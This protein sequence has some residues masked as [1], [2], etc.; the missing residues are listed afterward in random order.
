MWKKTNQP[1]THATVVVDFSCR[2]YFESLFSSSFQEA[3][4]ILIKLG[5]CFC[6]FPEGCR[7]IEGKEDCDLVNCQ[8]KWK[9]KPTCNQ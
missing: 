6:D 5:D 7:K 4:N 3:L 8:R 2:S 9:K 1:K